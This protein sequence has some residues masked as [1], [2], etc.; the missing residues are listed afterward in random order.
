LVTSLP[1]MRNG[2]ILPH[3][4]PEIRFCPSR[5]TT[6]SGVQHTLCLVFYSFVY[7]LSCVH[8]VASFSGLSIFDCPLVFFIVYLV[9]SFY[10]IDDITSFRIDLSPVMKKTVT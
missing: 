2:P 6:Y 9:A 8:Y 3:D 10:F 4:P 5:Y 1:V 7:F